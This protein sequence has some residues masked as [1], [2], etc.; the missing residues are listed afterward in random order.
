MVP[1]N[2]ATIDQAFNMRS[3]AEKYLFTCYSYM[4]NDGDANQNPAYIGGDEIWG[5]I[6]NEDFSYS[7]LNISRGFQ[8]KVNPY[9]DQFSNLYKGLRDCNIF[10]ENIDKVP[11]LEYVDKIRWIAEVK[12]LKAYYHFSLIRMYGPIPLIKESLPINASVEQA[13]V[14]RNTIDECFN[15]V[16]DLLD[17]AMEDL[18]DEINDP[19]YELGRITKP[20]AMALKAK[21]LVTAASPLFNG[22]SDFSHLKNNDGTSLFDPEVRQEKWDKAVIAC[23]EAINFCEEK[24]YSLYYYK[25]VF[26]RTDTVLTQLSI[27]NVIT[28]RWNNEI[29]WANTQSQSTHLQTLA[30]HHS[31][32]PLFPDNLTPYGTFAAPLILF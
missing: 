13:K 30:G 18:P 8:N 9:G 11:D 14:S 21:V 23:K 10:I 19:A 27:R 24:G 16:V 22:D 4:P 20:I 7:L 5:R 12:F 1:D 25:S 28:E 31:W 15:Y 26:N 6:N 29:I 2:I 32:D 3:T 17:E